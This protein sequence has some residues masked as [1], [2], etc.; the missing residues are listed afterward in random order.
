MNRRAFP[1]SSSGAAAV[2]ALMG[3]VFTRSIGLEMDTLSLCGF[4]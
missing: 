1:Q 4:C 2:P 3:A